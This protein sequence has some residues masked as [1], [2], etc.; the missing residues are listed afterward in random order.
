MR[1]RLTGSAGPGHPEVATTCGGS[2]GPLGS[3]LSS[4]DSKKTEDPQLEDLS[5]ERLVDA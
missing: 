2:A 4:D 1:E 3:L 5:N